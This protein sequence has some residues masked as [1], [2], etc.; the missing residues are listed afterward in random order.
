MTSSSESEG[1]LA[2]GKLRGPGGSELESRV[3][4]DALG[5]GIYG[6]VQSLGLMVLSL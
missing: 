4:I 5:F 6:L 3:R 1:A 2:A